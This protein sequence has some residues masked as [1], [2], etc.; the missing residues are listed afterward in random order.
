MQVKNLDDAVQEI[1]RRRDEADRELIVNLRAAAGLPTQEEIFSI[2]P[3]SDDEENGPAVIKN[4]FGRSLKLSLKGL[5]DKVPK[6]SKDYAKKSSNKKYAK[7]KAS[8]TPL[9]NQSELDQSSEGRNDLQQHEFGEGNEKN[10]GLQHQNNNEGADT[11]SS[12]VAG[13]LGHNEGMC[14]INQPGVLKHKFVDEVMVS[15]EERSSK[16]VQIKASK[17]QGLDTG[18]DTGKYASKSKTAKGKKLVIN[19]GARKI[20]VANSPKSDASSCQRE[21]DMITSNGI[22]SRKTSYA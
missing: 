19:L 3:Y 17:A 2:S 4:E 9:V 7:E 1:W 21:Q 8:Q 11:Y 10:G 14:S 6:K 18:E 5:V 12:P 20:N 22:V 16:V 13:S 15:D